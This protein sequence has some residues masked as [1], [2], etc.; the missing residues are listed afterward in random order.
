M[1]IT[2]YILG[3]N[4]FKRTSL[5][6]IFTD[7][8]MLLASVCRMSNLICT[9]NSLILITFFQ[10]LQS[11][12]LDVEE[13]AD[14]KKAQRHPFVAM[15]N[16]CQSNLSSFPTE[17]RK[18]MY[19]LTELGRAGRENIWLEVRTYGPRCARSVRPDRE[20]NISPSGPT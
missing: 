3:Q 14:W 18:Y 17:L 15:G 6:L 4:N 20:P 1:C 5:S 7:Y 19:L 9:K 2:C 12:R 11:T 16:R 13:I 10:I 8:L